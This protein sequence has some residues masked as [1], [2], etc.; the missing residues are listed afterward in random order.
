M[1]KTITLLAL[2]GLFSVANATTIN[3][4]AGTANNLAG[5]GGA[6][7]AGSD[8]IEVGTWDGATF[9]LL[10]TGSND[11]ILFGPGF[12][13]NSTGPFASASGA[14]LAFRWTEAA[15]GLTGMIYYDIAAADATAANWTLKGGN[16]SGSDFNSNDIDVAD[17]TTG[18]P[19]NTLSGNAVL[20]GVEFSGTNAAGVPSFNLVA[21]A[22][23]EPS[24]FA[25][26]AGL[27]ALG[28]VMVRRRRA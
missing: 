14:Q 13:G 12:F 27:C 26:L 24:T 20:I 25:A 5:D 8:D 16:G 23:P 15:S 28:A 10:G 7:L 9:S 22:V 19:Y 1:K 3:F 17:L 18:D 21:V 6:A 4:Q 11:N 2:V